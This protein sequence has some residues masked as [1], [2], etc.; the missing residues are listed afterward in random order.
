[1]TS[2]S[3]FAA[4]KELPPKLPA[5]H[6][7][8]LIQRLTEVGEGDMEAVISACLDA[9]WRVV[10]N[11]DLIQEAV[12]AWFKQQ[13]EEIPLSEVSARFSDGIANAQGLETPE[14][15]TTLRFYDKH[16]EPDSAVEE[17]YADLAGWRLPTGA[18][19][20]CETAVAD[21]EGSGKVVTQ[22]HANG[23][24]PSVVIPL[25]IYSAS[26]LGYRVVWC[27]NIQGEVGYTLLKDPAWEAAYQ[28]AAGATFHVERAW[29]VPLGGLGRAEVALESAES[30]ESDS[31]KTFNTVNAK[32]EQVQL[33]RFECHARGDAT[34]SPYHDTVCWLPAPDWNGEQH[35]KAS[36]QTL[37][38]AGMLEY[39][40]A[41][42]A[43]DGISWHGT[44]SSKFA[45][46]SAASHL[47][48]ALFSM[49]DQQTYD[50][51]M[52]EKYCTLVECLL[53]TE[54]SRIENEKKI[55]T[56]LA[57]LVP[58]GDSDDPMAQSFEAV[59]MYIESGKFVSNLHFAPSVVRRLIDAKLGSNAEPSPAALAHSLEIQELLWQGKRYLLSLSGD[60]RFV[61]ASDLTTVV[62]VFRMNHQHDDQVFWQLNAAM[63]HF[64]FETPTQLEVY[65]APHAGRYVMT[66]TD[67]VAPPTFVLRSEDGETKTASYSEGAGWSVAGD[68]LQTGS[69]CWLQLGSFLL[70]Q[71]RPLMYWIDTALKTVDAGDTRPR[72]YR[73]LKNVALP[74]S[75]YGDGKVVLWAA[76]SSSTTD[77]GV[78]SSFAKD[79]GKAAIFSLQGSTCVC[80]SPWSRFS[81]ERELL[82]PPNCTFV[83]TSALSSEQQE[84]LGV[85]NLQLF[86]MDEVD[87]AGTV[88][89]YLRKVVNQ[90]IS[91]VDPADVPKHVRQLFN[92]MRCFEEHDLDGALEHACNPNEP[93][94]NTMEGVLISNMLLELGASPAVRSRVALSCAHPEAAILAQLVKVAGTW[95]EAFGWM[96]TFEARSRRHLQALFACELDAVR[97]VAD[98][99][100]AGFAGHENL[101]M[102]L[103]DRVSTSEYTEAVEMT[104]ITGP[105][106]YL[107]GLYRR[108]PTEQAGRLGFDPHRSFVRENARV[109]AH[110]T[111]SYRKKTDQWVLTDMYSNAAR[112]ES[113]Q[114]ADQVVSGTHWDGRWEGMGADWAVLTNS[115]ALGRWE[116]L[117]GFARK[118]TPPT[119]SVPAALDLTDADR[120]DLVAE[121][122]AGG[123]GKE[124]AVRMQTAAPRSTAECAVVQCESSDA[125][126]KTPANFVKRATKIPNHLD[127]C[128]I[129]EIKMLRRHNNRRFGASML[130]GVTEHTNV[131]RYSHGDT[132]PVEG[133]ESEE[134]RL[135]RGLRIAEKRN[136]GRFA[137]DMHRGYLALQ[138]LDTAAANDKI[139]A[140]GTARR[141]LLDKRVLPNDCSS[142]DTTSLC[143]PDPSYRR[144]RAVLH[145]V[146]PVS[147][148]RVRPRLGAVGCAFGGVY[149]AAEDGAYTDGTGCFRLQRGDDGVWAL[150]VSEAVAR[151]NAEAAA[152]RV[153]EAEVKGG[154]GAQGSAKSVLEGADAELQ[155]LKAFFA[156][157]NL[158]EAVATASRRGW[159]VPTGPSIHAGAYALLELFAVTKPN[160]YCKG[161]GAALAIDEQK[162]ML[163]YAR[164]APRT[165]ADVVGE[166]ATNFE[167]K[168]KGMTF[169]FTHTHTHT[170][171]MVP[172]SHV[173]EAKF[174]WVNLLTIHKDHYTEVTDEADEDEEPDTHPLLDVFLHTRALEV[175]ENIIQAVRLFRKAML[176][177]DAAVTL[178]CHPTALAPSPSSLQHPPMSRDNIPDDGVLMRAKKVSEHPLLAQYT[179]LSMNG[180]WTD[181]SPPT[182]L[183]C[184]L[185]NPPHTPRPRTQNGTPLT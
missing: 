1:M 25:Y 54:E 12:L 172:W 75:V 95:D 16:Y 141:A 146:I 19:L 6:V 94:L 61:V 169:A 145:E 27:A 162:M 14:K 128:P 90:V 154:G 58:A 93:V 151:A 116:G 7:A 10:E 161:A 13:S 152:A 140:T 32:G 156:E 131:F 119:E 63:R 26:Q 73:G 8:E 138:A 87:A 173:L 132:A 174:M 62:E 2:G 55:T 129:H 125:R 175:A 29:A 39:L 47:I 9:S 147:Q 82:F 99:C 101:R 24:T 56:L 166:F 100:L 139:R 142:T 81:R 143:V 71:A 18:V 157:V 106:R 153:R 80:I 176:A 46:G 4:K 41:R 51:G 53:G 30:W 104:G 114:Y 111:L 183:V 64:Q 182:P 117:G 124:V 74:V 48:A 164:H 115:G 52:Y 148:V 96:A 38:P 180:H 126:W 159:S 91:S 70:S 170:T 168:C 3:K 76:Y 178:V 31:V 103:L 92:I 67:G 49:P 179:Q 135:E 78:A 118:A 137:Q 68:A 127:A 113:L 5:D 158:D 121:V 43:E 165:L 34:Y 44:W 28:A 102:Q 35:F 105:M 185:R 122:A 11:T 60:R 160:V 33:V 37:P 108:M 134:A 177:D 85:S 84:I 89:V 36:L 86:S 171:A 69:E 112:Q 23:T 109:G 21:L 15:V 98:T 79:E 184:A 133:G 72:T 77:R 136:T 150:R 66:T 65:K 59:K 50:A 155:R 57:S 167:A 40:Y 22:H 88:V 97:G 83:V 20:W 163:S 181:V 120:R 144:R 17:I 45:L 110:C 130:A 149:T 107:N 123:P 42:G